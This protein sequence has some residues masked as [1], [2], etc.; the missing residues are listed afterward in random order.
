VLQQQAL[1]LG[2]GPFQPAEPAG[3][4]LDRIGVVGRNGNLLGGYRGLLGVT[5]EDG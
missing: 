5:I 2:G 3:L 1:L 4:V